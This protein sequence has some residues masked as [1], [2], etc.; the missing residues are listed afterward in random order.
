MSAIKE[1]L[2]AYHAENQDG[3]FKLNQYD[4]KEVIGQGAFGVVHL[5]VDTTTG[6]QYAI[7]EFSKTRLRRRDRESQMRNNRGRVAGVSNLWGSDDDALNDEDPLRL[8]RKEIAIYKKLVHPNVVMLREVLDDPEHDA[9]FMVFEMCMGG[10]LMDVSLSQ[11]CEPFPVDKARRYFGELLLGIEYLH[12]NGIVH[13]DIKPENLLLTEDGRM[14]I[15]DF[16]V[17]EIFLRG[18]DTMKRSAGS[19]AFMAPEQISVDCHTYS[20]RAADIWSMG[21]TLFCMCYGKLPFVGD[22]ILSVYKA[23]RE[24][25]LD[26]PQEEDPR[27]QDLLTSILEKDPEQRIEMAELREHEWVT[28]SGRVPLLPY[29]QNCHRVEVTDE[30]VKHAVKSI[31][32]VVATIR[33]LAHWR[34]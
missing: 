3:G 14:K 23:I 19:P 8:V 33:A 29:E 5:A 31:H 12:A 10:V 11:P 18:D 27:L 20:G 9:L 13:R 26:L 7:K 32:N 22:S 24:D 17:S 34:R 25:V 28:D 15:A 6:T 2:S 1:T 30:E 4:V 16:G 21:V